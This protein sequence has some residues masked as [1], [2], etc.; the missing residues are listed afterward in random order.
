MVKLYGFDLSFPTNKVKF[1]LNLLNIDYQYIAL[2]PFKGEH[3]S[4]A[5]LQRHPAGKVPVIDDNGFTLFE[6]NVIVRYLAEKVNNTNYY[7]SDLQQQALVNQ[8]LDFSSMHIGSNVSKILFNR[9]FADKIG[10]EVDSRSMKEGHQFLI[11][12]LA[13][14]EAQLAKHSYIAGNNMTI[15]DI[16]LIAN[17]DPIDLI[18]ISLNDYPHLNN[19]RKQMMK[20]AFYTKVHQYYGEGFFEKESV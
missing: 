17:I 19:W 1:A 15:A 7:P 10:I 4:K 20:E 5:H 9:H 16:S 8:W 13:I 6:S 3:K 2:D 11:S 18:E 14:L 12:N